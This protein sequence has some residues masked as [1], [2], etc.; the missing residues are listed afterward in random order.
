MK[1]QLPKEYRKTQG[2]PTPILY[3]AEP[4]LGNTPTDK[5]GSLKVDIKSQRGER[6]NKT[7]AI[8]VPLFR[9][10]RP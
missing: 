10:G 3:K 4:T 5:S 2:P 9:T 8:Y 1:L 6:D 7:V